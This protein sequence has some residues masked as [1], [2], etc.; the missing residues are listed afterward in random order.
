[1]EGIS[2]I[3]ISIVPDSF[4]QYIHII[5]GFLGLP[6]GMF[7][8]P[9]PYYFALLP[10]VNEVSSGTPPE[11]VARLTLIGE[12]SGFAVSPVIPVAYLGVGLVGAKLGDHIKKNFLWFWGVSIVMMLSAIILGI[13]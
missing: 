7:M 4:N 11:T 6:I 5:I 10:I 8:G 3:L 13:F 9:D 12:S 2:D 1:I